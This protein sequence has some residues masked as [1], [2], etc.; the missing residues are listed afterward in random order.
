MLDQQPKFSRDTT[1]S[2]QGNNMTRQAAPMQLQ[3]NSKRTPTSDAQPNSWNMSGQSNFIQQSV[4]S[5]QTPPK[6]SAVQTE[7]AAPPASVV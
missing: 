3:I 5:M 2:D 7:T 4:N 6:V 1:E